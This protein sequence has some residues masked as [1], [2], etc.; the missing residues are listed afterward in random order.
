MMNINLIIANNIVA[1]M[2][3]K[4]IKQVDLANEMN[5]PKQTI[6]KMLN[7]SRMINAGE[8]VQI[9]KVLDVEIVELTALPTI[10]QG[11][12]AIRAFM[13][14]FES[15]NAKN[16]LA[17]ADELADMIVFHAKV[18]DNAA[19]MMKAWRLTD[20]CLVHMR[21]VYITKT[22]KDLKI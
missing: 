5:L 8:L 18:H 14:K 20:W 22:K 11:D 7:G 16:A 21:I 9:A 4:R 12:N 6:S 10:N 1:K 15:E 19:N 13:G 2:E 3:E 17:I